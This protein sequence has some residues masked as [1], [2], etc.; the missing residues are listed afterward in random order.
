MANKLLGQHFLNDHDA[1]KKIVGALEPC[2]GDTVFEIGPGHGELTRPLAEAYRGKNAKLYAIE[3]DPSLA[4]RLE[5]DGVEVMRG[6][7]L[8]VLKE[9]THKPLKI[10]GNIP[11][12]L[13]GHL[14]RVIGELDERPTRAVF[15]VQKEVAERLAATPPHM[16]RLAASIQIWAT[17]KITGTV[18]KQHF[19]P[20]PKIDSAIILLERRA[21]APDKE[22]SARY[23]AAMHALFAQPRKTIFNNLRAALTDSERV[24]AALE[25]QSIDPIARPQNL[26]IEQI[27]TI[28]SSLF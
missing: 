17:P 25:K 4:A 1:I 24:S 9:V 19:S 5:V 12:Y 21:D 6:N 23:Y 16:N 26:S 18:P 8:E 2:D 13:T 27:S 14:L 3:K 7:A 10:V 15:M 11:Y 28:A 22:F 20:Q